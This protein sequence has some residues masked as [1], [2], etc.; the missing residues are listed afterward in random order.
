MPIVKSQSL[1]LVGKKQ[2]CQ[3]VL[4]YNKN[5]MSHTFLCLNLKLYVFGILSYSATHPSSYFPAPSVI[6][7]GLIVS[8]DSVFIVTIIITICH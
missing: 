5:T 1:I 4:K 3:M 7:V 2:Y 8:T 6:I